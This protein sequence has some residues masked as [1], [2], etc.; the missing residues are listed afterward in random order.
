MRQFMNIPKLCVFV[1]VP[2]IN[3]SAV[4]SENVLN[5]YSN[6]NEVL[7]NFYMIHY[8]STIDNCE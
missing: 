8:K 6:P 1:P 2:E 3:H 5:K 4:I 7:P